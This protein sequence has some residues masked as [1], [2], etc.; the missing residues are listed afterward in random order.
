MR[1]RSPM[2]SPTPI[3]A[4]SEATPVANGLTVE[5]RVPTPAPT[6]MVTAPTMRSNPS[7][8]MI[9]TSRA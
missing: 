4:A 9:G 6:M 2:P 5:A 8:T 3:P 7:P 1:M